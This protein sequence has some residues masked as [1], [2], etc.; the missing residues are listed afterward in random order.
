MSNKILVCL[1]D[2][3]HSKKLATYVR[4]QVRCDK[5]TEVTLFHCIQSDD[6]DLGS[7]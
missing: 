6:L 7:K 2:L 4:D 3:E 5:G 1:D